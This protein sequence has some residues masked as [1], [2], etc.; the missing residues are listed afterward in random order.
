MSKKDEKRRRE[1]RTV[2]NDRN[3]PT[4]NLNLPM[5]KTNPPKEGKSSNGKKDG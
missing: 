4:L 2:Q 5:P 3:L 1:N